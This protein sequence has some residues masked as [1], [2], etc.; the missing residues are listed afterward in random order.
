MIE[1]TGYTALDLIGF[2]D[3]GVYDPDAYYVKNDITSVGN[4][5][6]RCLIDDTHNI[7]PT[8]GANWTIYLESATSLAGMDDVNIITPTDDDG[9]V[10]DATT[11][12]WKNKRI[13]TKEQW[14]KNGAYN[15]C[16]NENTTQ[17]IDGVTFT[18]NSD[19]SVTAN[20][21][22]GS[23]G[24]DFD[25]PNRNTYNLGIGTYKLVGCP[26]GGSTSS[27]MIGGRI[28]GSWVFDNSIDTGNGAVINVTSAINAIVIRI[29][30]GTVCNNLLFKPMLTTDLN[31]TYADYVP[32]AMTN[33]ELTQAVTKPVVIKEQNVPVTYDGVSYGTAVFELFSNGVKMLT[34]GNSSIPATANGVLCN[35]PSGFEPSRNL[36]YFGGSTSSD[37]HRSF[38]LSSTSF[39]IYAQQ[40]RA[41]GAF[42]TLTYI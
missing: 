10:Y 40:D 24:A 4:T 35:I 19:G 17:V 28:N 39:N 3:R 34:Y 18:V 30:P 21:T 23:T 36:L 38:F 13:T 29:K 7:P 6:W 37:K 11:Q 15:L 1:P 8:E 9:L 26:L 25:V 14:K 32:Y 42:V 22:C 41:H 33:R 27:Y 5:K 12:K 16:P 20:G 31:A 2:T